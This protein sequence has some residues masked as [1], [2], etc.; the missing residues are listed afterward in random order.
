MLVICVLGVTLT[1][2]YVM[3]Q[4]T[5]RVSRGNAIV[6]ACRRREGFESADSP[7]DES[8][9]AIIRIALH[10]CQRP[11]VDLKQIGLRCLVHVTLCLGEQSLRGLFSVYVGISAIWRLQTL[12][13]RSSSANSEVIMPC[14]IAVSRAIL[15]PQSIPLGSTP[16]LS[17]SSMIS[18]AIGSLW[19]AQ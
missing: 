14:L 6:P 1:A 8:R 4:T 9:D 3:V 5:Q 2:L 12:S 17:K 15:P 13:L 11:S 18:S 19:A 7:F 10:T 16:Y